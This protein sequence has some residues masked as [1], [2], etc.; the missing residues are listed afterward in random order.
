MKI[1]VL[2]TAFNEAEYLDWA[3]RGIKD[4][5]DYVV[6]VEGAYLSTIRTSVEVTLRSTDGTSDI[7]KKHV[8]NEKVFLIETNQES[9]PQQRQVGLN[10]IKELGCEWMMIV[11]GDEIYNKEDLNSI[12]NQVEARANEDI[13][14]V[15]TIEQIVFVNDFKHWCPMT[16]N[17]L[18][19]LNDDSK[20]YSDN[21]VS[22]GKPNISVGRI[23]DVMM[24]HYS[25]VKSK[26]RFLIKNRWA[27][28]RN[29]QGDCG[30]YLKDDKYISRDNVVFLFDGD[31]PDIM[32]DH[33]KY[34]EAYAAINS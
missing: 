13:P 3:I 5:A 18:F 22:N 29:P 21:D 31:H 20:F 17:R 7:I 28:D 14:D 8:D 30:W 27:N 16:M 34:K 33:P 12:R 11:D 4:W 1:G 9:D 15:F 23:I 25:Y 32:R 6:I 24:Y 10:K 2:M 19:R 26:D